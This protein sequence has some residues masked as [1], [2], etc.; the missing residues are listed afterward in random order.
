MN[1]LVITFLLLFI[2]GIISGQSLTDNEPGFPFLKNFA[3]FEYKAHAQNFAITSDRRGMIY[4]G[5]FAG[6]L[7]YD[8]EF[9]R[10]IPTEKTTKVSALATDS[11]G[12]IYVGARSEIGSL[13]SDDNG[14]MYFK[15]LLNSA[16]SSNPSFSDVLQIFPAAGVI[17]FVT[18]NMILVLDDGKLKPWQSPNEITN[19][20][21]VNKTLYLQLKDKGLCSYNNGQV[22]AA[23]D[24][25][26]FS[27]AIEIKAMLPYPDGRILI[28]TGTQGLYLFD[29]EG[30]KNFVA[31]SDNLLMKSLVTTGEILADGSYAIGTSQRGIII[32][33]SDG[34]I[35]QIIDKKA[36][37]R[38]EF[39][40]DLFTD[41]KNILWAALNNG[42]VMVEI[43]SPL[44]FFDEQSGLNGAVNNIIR[45]DNTLYI[46]TYQGLYYYDETAFGFL[47]IQ[48]IITAC[49]CTIPYE[50]GLLAATSQGIFQ[51]INKK[52]T[53]IKEGFA[54]SIVRSQKDPSS[55]FI[56]EMRGFF[57]LKK[58]NGRW[59][60]EKFEGPEVEITDLQPDGY[61]NIWGS[62]LS[63]GV[64]RYAPGDRSPV[65][66]TQKNGLPDDIGSS[67]NPIGQQM[68]VSTR[69]GVFVFNEATHSFDPITLCPGQAPGN[70]QWFSIITPT[71]TGNLWV[72]NGDET[73]VML[74]VK[75]GARYKPLSTPFLSISD[76][77]IWAIYPENNGIAWFGGP[78]GLIRYNPLVKKVNLDPSPTL[79]RKIIIRND[80]VI[81]SGNEGS[82]DTILSR[83]NIVLH[84]SD[85]S[86]RFEFS[87]PYYAA[88]GEN[89][90]QYILEG[91][92]ETWSDWTTQSHK[93]YTNLP[94]GDFQ[95]RV[96]SRNI[97]GIISAEA[98]V[99]FRILSPWFTT[100]WAYLMYALLA[101]G[102]IYVIMIYRNR[103]LMKEKRV[104]EQRI[105]A[106]T[107][108]VVQQKEE[109]EKQSEELSDKNDELEK[110]NTAV[111]SINVEI[112]FE[113]LLQSL[114]EKM[115][116]IRSAEKSSALVYDKKLDACKFKASFGWSNQQLYNI[117][118]SLN[119]AENCYLKN[120]EEIFEDIFIK[121]EFSSFDDIPELNALTKP[122]SMV[123][124][125]IRVENK[126]EAFLIFENLNRE[127]AFEP[128]D[129]SFI[130]NSKEHIISAFIRTRILE[131]LQ[132][133]LQNL[134]DTQDQ[135]VQSEKLA[136]LG[137]L[138][139]GIAH[140]IQ[141]PLNF[142]NNFSSL[143]ADL[144]DELVDFITGLKDVLTPEK[145]A[146]IDEVIG[147]IKGN[148]TKI[149]EHGKRAESIVKG[150]L[151]HS[152]GRTGEFEMVEINNMVSEYANLAYHGMRAKDKNFNTSIKTQ[153]DT[154]VG[155]ASVIPQD[156][157]RVILNIV[158]NSCYA[159]NEKVKKLIPG[160]SPEVMITTKKI[161]DKIEI[162]IRDNGSG[163]PEQVIEKIFNPFF[164]TK[165]TGKGTGLGLS[166]SYDIVTQVHKGKL[167]VKSKEGEFTEFII[168]I[169]EKQS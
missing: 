119:Q 118:L 141:N 43:P 96:K 62:T 115:K 21:Y 83:R 67:I 101:G 110:I 167:E 143:S 14:R 132:Q 121:T 123:I 5:N 33:N 20:F 6:V 156:L 32:I 69:K 29:S 80:S 77:V 35:K 135:L 155:K 22:A 127:N 40:Q 146:D 159:L 24:G 168:T 108:E 48:D 9:W 54:M 17:Y 30:I 4:F 130:K 74:L 60:F 112:N 114:L 73:D 169:P 65:F 129:V 12:K 148:V 98:D 153:L 164:T 16:D 160:F 85:N 36:S 42:I 82:G 78:D 109:I 27:D 56:G 50:N 128:K 25:N 8:G 3:P 134:K 113:N 23:P 1:K 57:S 147:M 66:Y 88:M 28:I 79:I 90:Y 106:R 75:S 165:P 39:V 91:F 149:N 44:T 64:F 11:A 92:E 63:K 37:I 117:T 150:M 139:A 10:L 68:S 86:L 51:V 93:E 49:W 45:I 138:I 145:Y 99:S 53:I 71:S 140:E 18:R 76:Y 87:S 102:L 151:Q 46:S 58:Q 142:V 107:A 41:D 19:A 152:R 13:E 120:A 111:K 116:V 100:F 136:S 7:Q 52:A 31:S 61:G 34:S 133:T 84:Y 72:N 162:R 94:K 15:S 154:Q 59:Q 144:A 95:F 157:S 104:L 131:N 122:K 105:A 55:I 158:N 97:Y 38:N 70:E 2:Q 166:M 137:E 103:Q 125:V 126:V 124:L 161:N 47:P 89:Q 81:Y 26:L 163:I